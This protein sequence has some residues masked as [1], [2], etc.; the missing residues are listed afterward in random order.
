MAAHVVRTKKL[1]VPQTS[2]DFFEILGQ[3]GLLSSEINQR[4]QAMVGFRNIATHDYQKLNLAIV[5]AIVEKHLDD[6]L[7]F[8]KT[9][10]K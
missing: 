4:M 6:F 2:R 8:S 10:L 9:L 1:G 7:S 5:R 3:K